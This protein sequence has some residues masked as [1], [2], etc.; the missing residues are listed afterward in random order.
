MITKKYKK[1]NIFNKISKAA[2][3]G[4]KYKKTRKMKGGGFFDFFKP[5]T[6]IHPPPPQRKPQFMI[7]KL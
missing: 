4:S 1:S 2:K 3:N 7:G 5:K 6:N